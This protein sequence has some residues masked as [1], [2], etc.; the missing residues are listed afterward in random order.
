[1]R[2]TI[3]MA[4]VITAMLAVSPLMVPDTDAQNA[5]DSPDGTYTY[6]KHGSGCDSSP[7]W[8][9]ILSFSCDEDMTFLQSALEGYE[10]TTV[11]SLS[12]CNAGTVVIPRTVTS[13]ADDALEGS[14]IDMMVFLGDRPEMSIPEDVATIALGGTSGWDGSQDT[15]P[16]LE[17]RENGTS[18]EYFVLNGMAYVYGPSDGDEIIIPD[19]DPNG[20]PFVGIDSEAFRHSDI[21]TVT[22]GANVASIGTRAFYNCESLTSATMGHGVKEIHDEAFRYCIHLDN[23]DLE[24]VESIGFETFRDCRSFTSISIPDSVENMG[25]GAFYICDSAT[26]LDLGSGLV[27]IPER[28]FGYC[29]SLDSVDLT[30]ASDIGA[31]AFIN[32]SS[33]L[34]VTLDKRTTDIG[35]YAFSGCT[36]L[37]SLDLGDRLRTVGEQAFSECRMLPTLTFPDTLTSIG[38]KPFFHCYGLTELYFEG[39]MPDIPED[40][41]F[42]TTD[43]TVHV[44]DTHAD[45]WEPFEGDVVVESDPN[46]TPDGTPDIV[47]LSMI[48]MLTILGVM[49][50]LLM[51]TRE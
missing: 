33:L 34:H 50:Y 6:A 32:C 44:Y 12:G 13:V 23:V 31:S 9:E 35:R 5:Y 4:I 42:G 26:S 14:S 46:G 22:F 20:H 15:I 30:G 21:V 17:Y 28:A 38:D 43:V 37:E 27:S 51:R 29:S 45:S 3:V 40:L 47:V 10:M 25:G 16:L 1:M 36:Y 18:F 41:L 7:Y 11:T 39:K 2:P 19:E 48:A 24:G 49:A 8:S